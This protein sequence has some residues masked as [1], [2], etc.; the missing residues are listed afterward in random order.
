MMTELMRILLAEDSAKL[1]KKRKRIAS[2]FV[3]RGILHEPFLKTC[4]CATFLHVV[5]ITDDVWLCQERESLTSQFLNMQERSG[6][7]KSPNSF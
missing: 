5:S 1:V 4:V 2:I 7:S 3:H 6:A